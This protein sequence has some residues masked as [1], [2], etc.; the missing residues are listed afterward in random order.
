MTT[1]PQTL[2]ELQTELLIHSKDGRGGIG[3][4]GFR[5]AI[6]IDNL[7]SFV[8]NYTHDQKENPC[9]R[10][11]GTPASKVS[12]AGHAIV[13]IL[14]L[15][16]VCEVDLQEAVEVALVNLREKDFK[17]REV[18]YT[19]DDIIV[20]QTAMTGIVK[21][22]AWVMN[23]HDERYYP[24]K[25]EGRILVAPHT[26]SDARLKRFV[27][28][29]MDHGGSNCHAGIIAREYGIPCVV[30]TGNATERIQDGDIIEINANVE[31][32]QVIKC[33]Q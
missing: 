33:T 20:G 5:L 28:I 11:H 19:S 29:V 7:G 30:G 10:P 4:A 27:G 23:Q 18:E 31:K 6:A 26:T 25:N 1:F 32:G 16:S 14:T 9:A 8:R 13:Q 22:K 12:D 24:H 3:D 21:G 17:K 15:I 2:R